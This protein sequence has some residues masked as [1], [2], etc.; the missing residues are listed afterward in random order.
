MKRIFIISFLFISF[1]LFAQKHDLNVTIHESTLG[2]NLL[3]GV[4]FNATEYYFPEN[5]YRIESADNNYLSI[6]L[7]QQRSNRKVFKNRGKYVVYDLNNNKLLWYRKQNILQSRTLHRG[8]FIFYLKDRSTKCLDFYTGE[9]LLSSDQSFIETRYNDKIALGY[10]EVS[11]T[12]YLEGVSL[13]KGSSF[14]I[15]FWNRKAKRASSINDIR[16]VND[17]T[18]LVHCGG[19]HKIDMKSGRGWSY[20]AR[21]EISNRGL[22]IAS[23]IVSGVVGGLTGAY[24]YPVSAPNVLSSLCSDI[25]EDEDHYYF[26]SRDNIAKISKDNG[27]VLWVTNFPKKYASKSELMIHDGKVVMLNYGVGN[28]GGKY[29]EYGKM[30]LSAYD[31]NNGEEKYFILLD[32]CLG[33]NDIRKLKDNILIGGVKKG[34]KISL[35]DGE[36]IEKDFFENSHDYF[37]TSYNEGFYFKAKDEKWVEVAD[38]DTSCIALTKPDGLTCLIDQNF[39]V[40]C[41]IKKENMMY[42]IADNSKLKVIADGDEYFLIDADGTELGHFPIATQCYFVDDKLYLVYKNSVYIID[43]KKELAIVH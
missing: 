29:E 26:A 22:V 31:I 21:T 41:E 40:H 4:G 3:S 36:I 35:S 20:D 6:F 43:T 5:V 16:Q 17:S 23:A 30:F 32:S 27:Q 15:G 2:N 13:V 1:G 8:N 24:F 42:R 25:L 38:V 19:L 18:L 33:I 11:G 12:V 28:F 7:L 39:N 14:G 34:F 37:S 10:L 9:K